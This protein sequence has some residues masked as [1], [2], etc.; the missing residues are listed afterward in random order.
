LK[1]LLFSGLRSGGN[2]IQQS[3]KFEEIHVLDAIRCELSNGLFTLLG[4]LCVQ[5]REGSWDGGESESGV[6]RQPDRGAGRQYL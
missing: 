3:K 1:S 6:R 2:P 4:A 5:H